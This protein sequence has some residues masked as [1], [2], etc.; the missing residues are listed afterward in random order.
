MKTNNRSMNIVIQYSLVVKCLYLIGSLLSIIGIIFYTKYYNCIY[1]KSN[2]VFIGF[3]ILIPSIIIPFFSFTTC[4]LFKKDN[5]DIS[6]KLLITLSIISTVV[7]TF[8]IILNILMTIPYWT[9]NITLFK[10]LTNSLYPFVVGLIFIIVLSIIHI[11][12]K[13]VITKRA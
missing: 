8:G 10:Y 3:N 2:I 11:N 5:K 7:C 9:D 4:L 6:Y 1:F 13:K 12:S